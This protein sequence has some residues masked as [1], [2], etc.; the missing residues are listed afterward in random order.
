MGREPNMYLMA[1]P[2][3]ITDFFTVLVLACPE[4]RERHTIC[5]IASLALLCGRI[6]SI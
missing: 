5:N 2:R 4:P 3:N 1:K 6:A